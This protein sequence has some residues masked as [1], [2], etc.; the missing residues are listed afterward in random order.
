MYSFAHFSGATSVCGINS[1]HETNK[2][3]RWEQIYTQ[4]C[5]YI[6]YKKL[7][8]KC[9]CDFCHK[10]KSLNGII[11]KFYRYLK[12]FLQIKFIISFYFSIIDYNFIRLCIE[13][14]FTQTITSIGYN[15]NNYIQLKIPRDSIIIIYHHKFSSHFNLH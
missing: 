5:L 11:N 7:Y 8:L 13:Y 12:L 15:S 4:I 6:V 10:K 1:H 9:S 3:L 14:L 2:S